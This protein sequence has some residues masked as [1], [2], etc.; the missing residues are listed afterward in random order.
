M[1]LCPEN[2][3]DINEYGPG[4]VLLVLATVGLFLALQKLWRDRINDKNQEI[5]RMAKT[6]ERLERAV[7]S[8]RLDSESEVEGQGDGD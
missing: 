6:I 8:K 1:L 7:L 4:Y 2:N 5:D 3:S